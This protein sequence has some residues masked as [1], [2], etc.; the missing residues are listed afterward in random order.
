MPSLNASLSEYSCAGVAYL[1][2]ADD[3][4]RRRVREAAPLAAP[5]EPA[6]PATVAPGCRR[7]ILRPERVQV[8]SRVVVVI[9][10]VETPARRY[11]GRRRTVWDRSAGEYNLLRRRFATDNE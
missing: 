3:V 11:D 1:N 4:S 10:G 2:P 9:V 8:W 6:S 7:T 5:S